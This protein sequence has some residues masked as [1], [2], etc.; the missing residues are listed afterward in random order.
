M[1][2]AVTSFPGQIEYSLNF[3]RAKS[4][5]DILTWE[6]GRPLRELMKWKICVCLRPSS[7]KQIYVKKFYFTLFFKPQSQNKHALVSIFTLKLLFTHLHYYF[8]NVEQSDYIVELSE[9]V[10]NNISIQFNSI[11]FTLL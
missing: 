9:V 7:Q 3:S 2:Y 6:E 8:H 11:L 4:L 5:E 10:W 1:R